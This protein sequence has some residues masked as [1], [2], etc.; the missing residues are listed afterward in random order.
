MPINRGR[1]PIIWSLALGLRSIGSTFFIM[2]KL[3][4]NGDII[5]QK[6]VRI[7]NNDNAKSL[8]EKLI[9]V[10]QKQ[11]VEIKG[12]ILRKKFIRIKQSRKNGNTLRK[13]TIADGIIDWRMDS[14]S[15][16]DLIRALTS[17]Y[18]GAHFIYKGKKIKVWHAKKHKESNLNIEPGKVLISNKSLIKIKC[19]V[20]SIS[21]IDYEPKINIL[22]G[23]YL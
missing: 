13:R 3:P 21:L 15:I 18:V 1:H 14:N 5:S 22:V 6:N 4:D 17:P 20:G 2:D 12:Q 19:G 23:D 16:Y 10:S 9:K 11:V 7:S 8:Y